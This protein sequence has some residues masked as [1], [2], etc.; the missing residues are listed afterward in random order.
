MRERERERESEQASMFRTTTEKFAIKP[1]SAA[2]ESK[3]EKTNGILRKVALEQFDKPVAASGRPPDVATIRRH[4]RGKCRMPTPHVIQF[5][6]HYAEDNAAFRSRR[7]CSRLVKGRFSRTPR[8]SGW[9]A[10]NA[11]ASTALLSVIA[12]MSDSAST[13]PRPRRSLDRGSAVYLN[14]REI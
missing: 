9:P 14:C 2:S 5:R 11:V 4:V 8:G 12:S 13:A 6:I 3:R 7:G 10:R 1:S